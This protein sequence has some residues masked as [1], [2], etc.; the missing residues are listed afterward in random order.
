MTTAVINPSVMQRLAQAQND[1]EHQTALEELMASIG[2]VTQAE[3][4]SI[5]A[6]M[7]SLRAGNR[8]SRIIAQQIWLG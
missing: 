7:A 1:A 6:A 5:S 3:R 2:R 8:F 4:E